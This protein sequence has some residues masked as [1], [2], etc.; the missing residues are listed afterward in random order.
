ML[1]RFTATLL[2]VLATMLWGFTFIAQKSATAYM[3]PLT[4]IGARHILGGLCILPLALSEYKRRGIA[5]SPRQWGLAAFL[6]FNFLAACYLQQVGVQFTTITN[7]GFLTGFYVFFVPLI[8]LVGFRTAPHPI[9]WLCA[10]LALTGLFFLN[11]GGIET[12][13]VGDII[14]LACAFFWGLHVLMLGYLARDTGLPVF[15]SCLSFLAAGAAAELGSFAFEAPQLDAIVNGWVEIAYAGIFSTA[16]AFTLQAIGQVHVPP[17]NAAI[18]LSGEALF[19]ALGGAVVL[20][21]RLLPMGYFGVGLIFVA[22][23]MVETV[24]A[25]TRKKPAT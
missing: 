11:G 1:N 23:V 22:I 24:P 8:L 17:A 10:P 14:I 16:I 5:L 6:S 21:E 13:N 12:M 18:I 4:Y 25:L 19:A 3:G 7:A 15:V 2:L 20:G 9:V